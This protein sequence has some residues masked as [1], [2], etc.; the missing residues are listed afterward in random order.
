MEEK[1]QRKTTKDNTRGIS[2]LKDIDERMDTLEILEQSNT[3]KTG[4]S[5]ITIVNYTNKS[6]KNT[7]GRM[8]NQM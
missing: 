1:Y 8:N 6:M 3:N 5:K 7:K 4:P 2:R